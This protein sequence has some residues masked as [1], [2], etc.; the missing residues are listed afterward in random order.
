MVKGWQKGYMVRGLK[1]DGRGRPNRGWMD[2][3]TSALVARGST[4]DQ[5]REIVHDRPIWR[6]LIYGMQF[7]G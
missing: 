3:V 2:G 4:L 7:G 1:G 6:G 5:A